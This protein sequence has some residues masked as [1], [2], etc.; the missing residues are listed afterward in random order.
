[1]SDLLVFSD[2]SKR[3]TSEAGDVD[4][5]FDASGVVSRQEWVGISGPSGSGKTSLLHILG[6]V[7]EPTKGE[8]LLNGVPIPFQDRG[9]CDILRRN[10]IGFVFQYFRLL[11]HLTAEENVMVPLLL[12]GRSYSVAKKDAADSLNQVGLAHRARHLPSALSGGEQQ[13]IA[14]AR[15]SAHRP[16]VIIAD[17]PTGNLDEKNRDI[18][19][20]LFENLR[21]EGAAIIMAS[22][23][24]VALQ[25]CSRVYNLVGGHITG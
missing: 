12:N 1:M 11:K 20:A 5:L 4:V 19:L 13:R 8:V 22:H 14:I 3:Y 7:D 18:V 21:Q 9:A 24:A 17:E 25:A 16:D 2:V 6:A 23:S 10:K 15:A